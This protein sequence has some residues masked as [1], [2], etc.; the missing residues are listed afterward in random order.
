MSKMAREE[1]D[2]LIGLIRASATRRYLF[3][4]VAKIISRAVPP[5]Y[6]RFFP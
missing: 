5:D 4:D 6:L 2:A 3:M 1:I